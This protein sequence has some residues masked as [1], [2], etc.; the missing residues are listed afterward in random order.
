[1]SSLS[2]SFKSATT[3][4]QWS[5]I[6]HA[7]TRL[8]GNVC[9]SCQVLLNVGMQ[10]T[11]RGQAVGSIHVAFASGPLSIAAW[12]R[13]IQFSGRPTPLSSASMRSAQRRASVVKVFQA[14]EGQGCAPLAWHWG[15]SSCAGTRPLL[16]AA[17]RVGGGSLDRFLG[18]CICD[19][20]GT[21]AQGEA[22]AGGGAL[23]ARAWGGGDFGWRCCCCA[24]RAASK[25]THA[26]GGALGGAL[27]GRLGAAATNG[28]AAPVGGV[29]KARGG[30]TCGWGGMGGCP[31]AGG[32]C[33]AGVGAEADR[34]ERRLLIDLA[35]CFSSPL[36][37][38]Q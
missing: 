18:C 31:S 8:M 6:S 34:R 1:M 3:K 33:R 13:C 25:A 10:R 16:L 12:I 14:Q 20:A 23:G 11:I 2:S 35:R 30:T 36:K 19:S 9:V 5:R 37:F 21:V 32:T 7:S 27:G 28:E 22:S 24:V 29:L 38:A 4:M 26:T 15:P 17:S